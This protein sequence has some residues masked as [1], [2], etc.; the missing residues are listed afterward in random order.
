MNA[1]VWVIGQNPGATEEIVGYPLFE[2]GFSGDRIRNHLL[3]LAGIDPESVRFDNINKCRPGRKPDRSGDGTANQM[4]RDECF[5]LLEDDIIHHK[6]ELIITLGDVAFKQFF[7]EM[8]RERAALKKYH[9]KSMEWEID[10]VKC[11]V[12]PMYHPA[13]ATP[14]R[15]AELGEIQDGDWKRI[16]YN[17]PRLGNYARVTGSESE[18]FIEGH[19]I[20]AFD[21]ETTDPNWNRT[22]QA[23]RAREIGFSIGTDSGAVYCE[24]SSS[25]ISR[26]LEDDDVAVIAHNAK[27]EWIVAQSC[28]INI[29]N[30]HDTKLMAYVLRKPSTEL[31]DLAW[32]ELGV[33]MTRFEE[34]DWDDIE[35]VTQYGAADS[36]MTYQLYF[37]LKEQLEQ[38]GMW[39]IYEDIERPLISVLAKMEMDGVNIDKDP[40][41]TLQQELVEEAIHVAV[42]IHDIYPYHI[43]WRSV[44]QKSQALYGPPYWILEP[45]D[46]HKG[47]LMHT[48]DCDKKV[49]AGS[50]G[51]N[52]SD[53]WYILGE[54]IYTG[55]RHDFKLEP[56][57]LGLPGSGTDMEALRKL[58]NKTSHPICNLLIKQNSINRL[59]SMELDYIPKLT[60]EDGR[61]H[62]S[63]HQAG[64]WEERGGDWKEATETGRLSSSGPNLQNITH[65]GD[66]ERPY[67]R[68]WATYIR[69]AFSAPEGSYMVKADIGQEEPRIAAILGNDSNLEY[70]LNSG[71]VYKPLAAIVFDKSEA[72]IDIEERQV[73]K[74]IFL[75]W[76]Y[77][78]RDFSA[79]APWITDKHRADILV[80]QKH[81]YPDY[82]EYRIK[83]LDFLDK[84]G[85]TKTWFG[86][87]RAFPAYHSSRG[88]VRAEIE[89][90]SLNHPIQGS[91]ADVLK[92]AMTKV[93]NE[94]DVGVWRIPPKMVLNVHDEIVI[95]IA[96]WDLYKTAQIC[97][98]MTKDILPI[99][100]PVE[101]SYGPNWEDQEEWK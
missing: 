66:P 91:A 29:T 12:I 36:D 53:Q 75:E 27:F 31:K 48:P 55:A 64:S 57:G 80:Y 81:S 76:L 28:G 33:A 83:Q 65:H 23:R 22:F 9:G 13:S 49:K 61:I 95:E 24:A 100:L 47:R 46:E 68:E 59:L 73:G 63:Y 42:D 74:A 10:G 51:C 98:N 21:Y 72:L 52:H 34:V 14:N 99:N 67:I 41:L 50:C 18:A 87:R 16:G 15:H 35:Q 37:T 82:M 8:R 4:E 84:W 25:H 89:R 7:P 43:N 19:S 3:P 44:K 30:L 32:N 56:P 94:L 101:V 62:C 38:Q 1:K 86:R 92:L 45:G 11:K 70:C 6:P 20:F 5:S 97:L 58:R 79:K 90:K 88:S 39:H 78:G 40:L 2:K 85:Y 96:K 93:R 71:D 17:I 69:R 54:P 60:Q 77:E 26:F